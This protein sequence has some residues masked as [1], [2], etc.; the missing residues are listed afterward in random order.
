VDQFFVADENP[1]AVSVRAAAELADR[2]RWA[3]AH[4][5]E[6]H[7]DRVADEVGYDAETIANVLSGTMAPAWHLVRKLGIVLGVPAATIIEQWHPLWIAADDHRRAEPADDG[8]AVI[9]EP[10]GYPCG[11][12]GSFVVDVRLHADWHLR[13]DQ[14]GAGRVAESPE[15]VSLRDAVRRHGR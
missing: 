12:C 11:R 6:P 1:V 15:W 4:A 9:A 14:P 2:L 7:L 5:G 3:W 13:L 8:T 10:A